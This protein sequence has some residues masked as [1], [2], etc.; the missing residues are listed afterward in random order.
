MDLP[1]LKSLVD[2]GRIFSV[3]FIK[4]TDGRVRRM[5]GRTRVTSAGTGPS[6]YDP[7]AHGLLIVYDLHAGGFRTVPADQVIRVK[8]HGQQYVTEL[9]NRMATG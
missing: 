2:D 4:R 6:S 7:D 5:V 1:A 3:E 8:H 9:A